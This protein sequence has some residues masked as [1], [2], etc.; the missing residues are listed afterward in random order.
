MNRAIEGNRKIETERKKE[1]REKEPEPS[2]TP[3]KHMDM[4]KVPVGFFLNYSLFFPSVFFFLTAA[5]SAQLCIIQ[6]KPGVVLS[7]KSIK[8]TWSFEEGLLIREN[9]NGALYRASHLYQ[10]N[11][12]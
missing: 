7:E 1:K 4:C 2:S 8:G 3:C 5:E 9:V 11:T 10:F 6:P 12:F